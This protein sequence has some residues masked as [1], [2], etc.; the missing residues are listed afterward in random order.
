M[1]KK[2]IKIL[3][4]IIIISLN[5]G[6]DQISKGY[7]RENL[8]GKGTI[9]V[10]GDF[11]VLVYAEN[12]G[13][14]LSFGYNFPE[15]FKYILLSIFP[16]MILILLTL[17]MLLNF[18]I[19]YYLSIGFSFILGGGFSNIIDRFIY[20]GQVSDFMN[21]GINQLRTGIFNFADLSIITG[22]LIIFFVF[23]RQGV[24]ERKIAAIKN[25]KK[26]FDE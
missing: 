19:N 18:K 5:I 25:N 12:K 21:M 20:K 7:A 2:R 15:P 10:L 23:W 4:L 1:I 3:I 16:L 26:P 6:C 11:F 17:F 9:E 13:A 22:F 24:I 8:Q 14:F